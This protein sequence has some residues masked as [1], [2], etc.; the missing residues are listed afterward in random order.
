MSNFLT[1]C[2]TGAIENGMD[3]SVLSLVPISVILQLGNLT[4][5]QNVHLRCA[6]LVHSQYECVDFFDLKSRVHCLNESF[7]LFF[8]LG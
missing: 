6:V 1:Q 4:F 7:P 5:V 2:S 8:V 3:F